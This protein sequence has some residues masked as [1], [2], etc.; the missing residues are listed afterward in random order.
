MET[1]IDVR[2]TDSDPRLKALVQW[3]RNLDGL[4]DA[5]PVP[6]S[7]DAS[8]RRYFR[9]SSGK[10]TYI[11]MDA[12]P[13]HE[14]CDPFIRISGWLNDMRLNAPVVLEINL[15]QGFLL[16]SDLGSTQYLDVL[17]DDRSRA[18]ELYGDA[19]AALSI[20]QE[21]GAEF[22]KLLPKYDRELLQFELSIFHDWLCGRHLGIVFDTSERAQWQRLCE[23]SIGNCLEQQQVFVHRDYHSRNLMLADTNNPG[24]LDFQDALEGPHTYDLVSLL[25]DCYISWPAEHVRK[26][27]LAFAR[28]ANIS[29][30]DEA[31]FLRHFELT[32]LQRQLKAAGIFARLNHR[33]GKGDYMLDIPRTLNYVLEIAPRYPE[34]SFLAELIS[35]R[36]LPVLREQQS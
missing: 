14:D 13:T 3:I 30:D 22:Q 4:E 17:R 23:L 6:A 29:D 35:E 15:D 27:A 9:V 16:L 34:L 18:D 7:T 11:V 20:L 25:K 21:A 12:P 31:R 5:M 19:L 8:F 36:I 33:D 1:G 32:G 24:I 26:W 10:K 28:R 2:M